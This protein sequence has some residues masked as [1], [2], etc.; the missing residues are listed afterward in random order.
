MGSWDRMRIVL[1]AGVLGSSVALLPACQEERSDAGSAGASPQAGQRASGASDAGGSAGDAGGGAGDAGGTRSDGGG[2]ASGGLTSEPGGFQDAQAHGYCGRLFRCFEGNDDFMVARLLLKT[3]KG[4]EAQLRK[5]NE[6]EPGRRDLQAQLAA[7]MLHY[8]AAAGEKCTAELSVCNGIDSFSD[9]SC[10]EMFDGD[11][12]TGQA[13]QRSEDCAGDAYC[14]RNGSAC[15][16]QCRPRKA[17]GEPCEVSTDCAYAAGAVFCDHDAPSPVCRTLPLGQK[18]GMGEPC[19]RKLPGSEQLVTCD[20]EL[21][22]GIDAALGT[23]AAQGRCVLPLELGDACQDSD[24]V[25]VG[26]MCDTDAGQCRE[27]VLRSTEGE[28]C[29]EALFVACDPTLGLRC[30]DLGFCEAS[31]DGSE[32][33]RC[34]NGDFQRG[35]GPGLYCAPS[36][37]P[38]AGTCQ[39]LV[40]AGA[41]CEQNSVCDSGNCETTCQARYCGP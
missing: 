2:T 39:P 12:Q 9:G 33:S 6:Q 18:A 17:S 27:I 1:V 4:C 20:D 26:G 31:G 5:L 40:S 11:V 22:C 36:D 34:F 32:G 25:C 37:A 16:G 23:D 13:C 24:D 38:P 28:T 15:P 35:C 10:R 29:G 21:W 7:G 41:A 30:S 3:P 14:E 8:D 19:T